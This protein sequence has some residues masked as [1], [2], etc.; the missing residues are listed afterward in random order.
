MFLS[1]IPKK[2]ENYLPSFAITPK[3]LTLACEISANLERIGMIGE[4]VFTPQLRK[5]KRMGTIHASLWMETNRLTMEQITA[6]A[7]GKQVAGSEKD[8]LEVKNTLAAYDALSA[9]NPYSEE[10]LLK[11]HALLMNGLTNEPGKYR[12]ADMSIL[13]SSEPVHIAPPYQRVP[14]FMVQLLD[15]AKNTKLPQIVKSSILHYEIEIL[16]PFS[17]GNGRISRMWQTLLLHQENPLFA[18]FPVEMLIAHNQ[19]EYYRAL[20]RSIHHSN[21]GIFIQFML[22]II[23]QETIELKEK[24]LPHE[25]KNT[26]VNAGVN[27]EVNRGV[28]LSGTQRKIMAFIAKNSAISQSALAKKMKMNESS[29]YR[30]MKILQQLKQLERKGS[31]KTGAWII[32]HPQ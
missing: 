2:M 5:E 23:Q 24:Y 29:I 1:F 26:G 8:I 31:D 19:Q 3:I 28:K 7:N 32:K 13:D 16:H 25:L 15:W 27:R 10:D 22:S 14:G 17:E 20:K 21:N 11:Q 12:N 9:C 18:W 30:N 4:K 6:I